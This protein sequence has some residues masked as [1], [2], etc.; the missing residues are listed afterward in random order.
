MMLAPSNTVTSC[1]VGL[2]DLTNTIRP[3]TP[4]GVCRA[5]DYG[6]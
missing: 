2:S 3:L 6:A 1:A 5:A 4:P